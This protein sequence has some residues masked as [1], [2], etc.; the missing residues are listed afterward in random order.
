MKKAT[1]KVTNSDV[2]A[3]AFR[4]KPAKAGREKP[5]Q[6]GLF[7]RLSKAC[8]PGFDFWKPWATASGRGSGIW[9]VSLISVSFPAFPSSYLHHRPW[10]KINDWTEYFYDQRIQVNIVN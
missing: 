6:A 3:L 2:P 8:G 7:I 4:L 5:G 10:E 9:V 1:K